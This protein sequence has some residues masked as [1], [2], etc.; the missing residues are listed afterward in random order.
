MGQKLYFWANLTLKCYTI[1]SMGILNTWTSQLNLGI[2]NVAMV[3]WIYDNIKDKNSPFR[4][5]TYLQVIDRGEN[6]WVVN[7]IRKFV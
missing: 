6:V 7:S 1:G 3:E 4:N 2:G 5:K